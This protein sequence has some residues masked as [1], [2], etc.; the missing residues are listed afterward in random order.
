MK[1]KRNALVDKMPADLW[2]EAEDG[3]AVV[4]W[5][6]HAATATSA[7]QRIERI[8]NLLAQSRNTADEAKKLAIWRDELLVALR[9]Y[10]NQ[11]PSFTP[12]RF[13]F[14]PE[15]GPTVAIQ[16]GSH[17]GSYGEGDAI[18]SVQRLQQVALDVRLRRCAVCEKWIFV[19]FPTRQRFC[20]KVCQEKSFKSTP[21]FKAQR[22]VW[23]RDYQ[24]RRRKKFKRLEAMFK[25]RS[26]KTHDQLKRRKKP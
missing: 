16:V 11:N 25:A 13:R 20:G 7:R 26:T 8:I 10:R 24:R 2:T 18:V 21:Q 19:K 6:N 15:V 22:K 23:A 14:R 3:P 17:K 12:W 9:P 5:L 4:Q 1:N